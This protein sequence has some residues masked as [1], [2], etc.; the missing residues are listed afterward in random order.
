MNKRNTHKPKAQSNLKPSGELAD[1]LT[2]GITGGIG[3][4]KSTVAHLFE[5][6]GYPVYY[7]DVRSKW[8][9]N[10]DPQIKTQ[11]ITTFGEEVYPGYLDRQT[12]ADIVFKD[13]EALKKLNAISHPAVEKDFLNWRKAQNT[14]ILFKEAAILFESGSYKSVD[15]TICITAPE[16]IRVKRVMQR[17][18]ATAKQVQVRIANQW[19]D[20]KK[21]ALA[22]FVIDAG[23]RELV[24]PQALKIIEELEHLEYNKNARPK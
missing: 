4:G 13:K 9:M 21:I 2:I 15:K 3:S 8:L 24:I 7:A 17:D 10:N 18:G 1:A 12:L 19:S 6:M 5:M 22:D 23:D 20:E 16:V 14:P 11:L